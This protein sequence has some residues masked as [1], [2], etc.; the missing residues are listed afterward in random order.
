MTGS[1]DTAALLQ[2][3]SLGALETP[4]RIF[5]APLTRNRAHPDGTPRQMA[6]AYY[7]QRASAGLII[8]EATQISPEGKGYINTPGIHADGHVAAWRAITDAVH[9]AGGRIALQ[10]WHVGRMSHVSLQP[11]GQA[12]VAPSAIRADAQ[13][14]TAEGFTEVSPP[15]ALETAEIA[16]VIDD[17]RAAARRAREAGFDAVEVHAAN[18]YLL[19]QFIHPN[20]NHRTDGYGGT[21]ENRARLTLEVTRAA[22]EVMGAD[23]VGVR[24]SPTGAF[25]DMRL[26][27]GAAESFEVVI[28]GL[29]DIGAAY[30][31]MIEKFPGAEVGADDLAALA[32]MRARWRGA[33]IANGDFDRATAARWVREGKAS[34]ITF[35]RPFLANPDLPRRFEIGAALNEPDQATFYGGDERGYTDYPALAE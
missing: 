7:R 16:R 20:A 31:H 22:A 14:F 33:Y 25:G 11:N 10:L 29:N 12:P 18:G 8:T 30:L 26:D 3:L 21:A 15:R 35:G 23:R 2:P 24:L 34:A 27:A 4:N 6:I 13:V 9:E 32:R 5:M 19:D 1:P 28:D 17:F